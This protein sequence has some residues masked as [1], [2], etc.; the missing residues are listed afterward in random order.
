MQAKC[1]ARHFLGNVAVSI[2]RGY[3]PDWQMWRSRNRATV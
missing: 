2:G 1:F 3:R